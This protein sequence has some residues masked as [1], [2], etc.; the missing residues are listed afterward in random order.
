MLKKV[1]FY[2]LH[3]LFLF[4]LTVNAQVFPVN[5]TPQ[6]I[7]PYSLKL[8]EYGSSTSEKLLL[9]LLLTD[10]TESNRQVRLKFY[11][12]NNAGLSVQSSDVVIGAS[13]IFLDGGVPL[14]LSNIDLR[15]YFELQNLRGI[16]PRQYSVPL[17]EGLYKFCYEVYD[18]L[19]G[20]QISRKS[21]TAVYL[22]LNDPP[23][24]NT[25]KRGEQVL[26]RN[27]Q[28]IVFDWTP[29][30]LNATNVEYEFTISEL[31]DTQMDP[32]AGFLAS[33]PLY[34]TTTR[35][36]TLLYGPAE[37]QLLNDK[38][39]GWR[40]RAIVSDGISETSVF[41]N[42]GFSEINHFTYTGSCAEPAYVLAEAKNPTTEK[43]LW[44]GEGHIRYNVEYRKKDADNSIWFEGGTINEYTSI[45]NL[46]PGTTYEF[47]V[48]GQCLDNGPFTYSQIYEF[49]TTLTVDEESTYNCG[50]TPE[51]V[52]N[53]QD[54]LEFMGANETFTAGDF[55]VTVREVNGRDG[56]FSGWGFIVVPY[57]Q[58][59]KIKVSFDNIKINTDYQLLDGVVVTDYDEDWGGMGSVNELGELFEGD[60]DLKEIDLNFDITID[61]I[62]VNEDGSITVT[63]PVSG[64]TT[65]YP[66]GDD[67]VIRDTNNDG[68]S[69]TFHI[70]EEGNIRE[71]D[72]I[73]DGGGV[74]SENTPGVDKDGNVS[75]LT[76]KGVKITFIK[77]DSYTYGFDEIPAG[78]ESELGKHYEIIKD[79]DGKPYNIINKAVA[80]GGIDVLKGKVEISDSK[81]SMD[82]L[83]IKT[84]RGEVLAHKY[85]ATKKEITIDL[86]GYYSFEHENIYAILKPMKASEKQAVAG[87]FSLWHLA[88]KDVNVTII[89]VEGASLPS[90][91][92]LRSKINKI[93][94]KASVN[95]N[96]TLANT[97]RVDA[98]LYGDDTIEIGESGVFANYTNDQQAIIKDY[99]SKGS[100][101]LEA[102]YLFVFGNNIKPSRAI[103]GFMPIKRQFGFIFSGNLSTEEEGKNSLAGTISHEL[104]HGI[105]GLEHPFTEL[106]TTEKATKW[107]MDYGDGTL[108]SHLDWSQI[109]NPDFKF[110]L[111]QDDED[112]EKATVSNMEL[113]EPFQNEDGSFT[114]ISMSGKPISLPSNTSSVTFSS[115]DDLNLDNCKD[116]F[117]IEPFGSLKG[118]IIDNVKYSFCASCNSSN[119]AGYFKQG[120]GCDSSSKY[121][122][123]LS[124]QNNKN[125]L[126][127]LPC[128]K[129]NAVIFKVLQLDN[130]FKDFDFNSITSS[131]NGSGE[132][133]PYDY[134]LE[135]FNTVSDD[136]LVY[137]PADFDPKFD[138]DVV[139]FLASEFCF[140]GENDFVA[141]A[142]GFVYA[143]QLQKNKEYLGC[144]KT[145]VPLFFY[146][147]NTDTDKFHFAVVKEWQEKNINGFT[148]LK[149][150]IEKFKKLKS[151]FSASSDQFALHD[152]LMRYVPEQISQSNVNSYK[153]RWGTTYWESGVVLDKIQNITG[154]QLQRQ[155]DD[156]FCLWENI[157]M[158]DRLYAINQISATNRG[159]DRSEEILLYLVVNEKDVSTMIS[160]L[161]KENYKLF[162]KVWS[163]LDAEQRGVLISYL[164]TKLITA[165]T[166]NAG[167]VAYET[168]KE[169]C[170]NAIGA[171]CDLNEYK[172]LPLWRANALNVVDFSFDL[173][174]GGL[175][176]EFDYS[177]ETSESGG[178]VSI[179]ASTN[180]INFNEIEDYWTY[181]LTSGTSLFN[182]DVAPFKPIVLVI[183]EDIKLDGKVIL[184]KDQIATV[185][186]IFLHWLDSSIDKEQNQVIIRVAA[187]GLIVASILATGG[188]TTPLL[189]LDLIVFGT[190]FVFQ[191]ANESS[192]NIDPEIEKVW[193]SIYNFYNIANIPRAVVATAGAAK[194]FI[195]FVKNTSTAAKWNKIVVSPQY[196]DDY[197]N[198]FKNLSE[199]ER[200]AKIASEIA[201]LDNIILAL[202]N[203]PRISRTAYI[204][205]TLY[206]N[207]I[208]ARLKLANIQ[209]NA[210]G[211]TMGVEASATSFL[212]YLKVANGGVSTAVA[213]VTNASST[214]AKLSLQSVRW[215]P[216][217]IAVENTGIVGQI[218]NI[219]YSDPSGASKV[220]TLDI[221]KDKRNPG[222]FYLKSTSTTSNAGGSSVTVTGDYKT[223]EFDQIQ[224]LGKELGGGS[225]HF[226][227]SQQGIEGVFITINGEKIPVSLKEVKPEYKPDGAKNVFREIKDN[228]KSILEGYQKGDELITQYVKFNDQA[229]TYI[230]CDV[231]TFT[232]DEILAYYNSLPVDRR[233]FVFGD[234]RKVFKEIKII[235]KNG[236]EILFKNYKLV[237]GQSE[238]THVFDKFSDITKRVKDLGISNNGKKFY[239][240][241][242]NASTS[243]VEKIGKEPNYVDAWK[244]L[245]DI[246]VSESI[247]KNI[248][249]LEAVV[250]HIK[251]IGGYNKWKLTNS[252]KS[253][254]LWTQVTESN[255]IYSVEYIGGA[256]EGVAKTFLT[257]GVLEFDIN[258]PVFLQ[259]QGV[260]SAIIEKALSSNTTNIIKEEWTTSARYPGGE[261]AGLT[262][263]KQKVSGGMD[264]K[265][266]VFE[267]PT[268]KIYKR[269]GFDAEPEIITNKP[270]EVVVNFKR[271]SSSSIYSDSNVEK[272]VNRIIDSW[273]NSQKALFDEAIETTLL[274]KIN[275]AKAST[276][277]SKQERVSYEVMD[278]ARTTL[279][280]GN[281]GWANFAQSVERKEFFKDWR[282]VFFMNKSNPPINISLGVRSSSLKSYADKLYSTS[283][284]DFYTRG[285]ISTEGITLM[286]DIEDWLKL[287]AQSIKKSHDRGGKIF[288]HTDDLTD[289][290]A[291][292]DT[293]SEFFKGGTITE[294][295]Y[296]VDNGLVDKRLVEFRL[297]EESLSAPKLK[298]IEE[299]IENYKQLIIDNPEMGSFKGMFNI[300]Y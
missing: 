37:P 245:D 192:D 213:N 84:A 254:K 271:T 244:A 128:V 202:R 125:A 299:A 257:D 203:T 246:G 240:D 207:M 28:N 161:E 232:A 140:C 117:R 221:I 81:I 136:Q 270:D 138:Q 201:L 243:V 93:F 276:T 278:W 26:L 226:P 57:L 78:Q 143:T 285:F 210:T 252:G 166:K 105:F 241:F 66:A 153:L 52:I 250:T 281:N 27:P 234:K 248:D 99:K 251:A 292:Y 89:P 182:S 274:D 17:K 43:I 121:I 164:N 208:S 296:L 11:L 46:E 286:T 155:Y 233:P 256:K 206:R 104:G 9:N 196:I 69:D 200:A 72:P 51:I 23:F 127:G 25:P 288:F 273:S 60:N 131:Y 71:G 41:K 187:D 21:C 264:P 96:I 107:L 179:D 255:T 275:I 142:Y 102:Y 150:N 54:P 184:K 269:N 116:E 106:G 48:G 50:I 287:V 97:F 227:N 94:G 92:D 1:T 141:T 159:N 205:P 265:K 284:S 112:G 190:D 152:F 242:A 34:Q 122:D 90:E 268:G 211:I 298:E 55:P 75:Q 169:N 177:L 209:F 191:I 40:V 126:A 229:N 65:D 277:Y 62:T 237:G 158:D 198:Q 162:W 30:H 146:D 49:T 300:N 228:E 262:I 176:H 199:T 74:D 14:R 148:T 183:R 293:S 230:R 19:S 83:V 79:A 197:V 189:T 4:S 283:F 68:T 151:T 132:L 282:F 103:G 45:Y 86:K 130:Y 167:K 258:I 294:L 173:G 261:A 156:I 70:D 3:I 100:T 115:G 222:Q 113:L 80:N 175:A 174:P 235:G 145:G 266:A 123:T 291:L 216:A 260:S 2:F 163:E 8:S 42:D 5:V 44:Q 120:T 295:R 63:H 279:F 168:Y 172:I 33:R 15:P 88:K 149:N 259:K 7:P 236:K 218:K 180:Y 165:T 217:T 219:S 220:G 118:F 280:P 239:D 101:S 20:R 16:N 53:N 272:H 204:P 36:T 212:P 77:S 47:R 238:A 32:Q 157:S 35:A 214:A 253:N 137:L 64:V 76:A 31:W 98:S 178:N 231:K 73:A 85:D 6:V 119:F 267:T 215:L 225:I 56:T 22:V 170:E 195:S 82:S 144:F 67:V 59:T 129:D 297:G 87:L 91:S 160:E 134:I 224:I 12:E 124:N 24:L 185:P 13:P 290:K 39:Y 289:F 193:N 58:D 247:R 29:R 108:L 171:D 114:F 223:H 188:A 10:I 109:H 249:D 139:D 133:K 18:G 154:S 147:E 95:V 181:F 194:G 61:D 111:F 263:F 186:A 110:Y 135:D 38:M